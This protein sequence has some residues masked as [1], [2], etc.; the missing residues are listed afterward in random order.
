MEHLKNQ[1]KELKHIYDHYAHRKMF[2][3]KNCKI[4]YS[5]KH[6]KPGHPEYIHHLSHKYISNVETT[7]MKYKEVYI[8][9]I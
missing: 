4:L 2:L 6:L 9:N 8:C 3:Y 5:L 7:Q 1:Q